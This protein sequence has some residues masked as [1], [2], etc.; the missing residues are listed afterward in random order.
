M[1]RPCELQ[2]NNSGAWKNVASFD[3]GDG[4][5]QALLLQGAELIASAVDSK[6]RVI[7]KHEQPLVLMHCDKAGWKNWR[8]T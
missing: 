8:E 6:F 7:T 3:A 5:T 2:V 1:K 4:P